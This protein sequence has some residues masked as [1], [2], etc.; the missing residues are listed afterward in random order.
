MPAHSRSEHKH[1][2]KHPKSNL[3]NSGSQRTYTAAVIGG[4]VAGMATAARLA[5]AGY[6]VTL[7]EAN[8]Y[9]GG[10]LSDEQWEGFRFDKGPSLF[11]MPELIDELFE[12]CGK[13]AADY[14]RYDRLDLVTRYF[15]GDGT[16]VNAYAQ[17]E[18]LAKELAQKVGEAESKVISYLNRAKMMYQTTAPVFLQRSLHDWRNL[19]RFS[20]FLKVLRIPWLGTHTTMHKFNKGWFKHERTV[21][22]FDRFAT[23]NGSDPYR[24]P[25]TLNLISYI[26]HGLGAYYPQGGMIAIRNALAQLMTDMGVNVRLQTRIDKFFI[27]ENKIKGVSIGDD[28]QVFDKVVSAVDITQVRQKLYPRHLR[29]K[30]QRND[31]LSTSAIIFHW[32][33]KGNFPQLDLHN[34]FFSRHYHKEFD[35]LKKGK[36]TN[37][38]TVYVYVSSKINQADAPQGHENWFVMVNTPPNQGQDWDQYIAQTRSYA[39]QILSEALRTPVSDLV[40]HETITDP[41]SLEADTGSLGGAIYGPASNSKWSAFL[42]QA[43]QHAKIKGLYFVGGSVHPGGGIPLCLLSARITTELITGKR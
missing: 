8:N 34:I 21:Q 23:Y 25:A 41:R 38:P 36:L 9:L 15:Y 27:F 42:R 3:K 16:V 18:K 12:A 37:D 17:P 43:N 11:T 29:K 30:Y 22:L 24:A 32:A 6:K 35:H 28:K 33:V 20:T 2:R 10:K 19:L 26:E 7:F 5:A 40:L 1:H 14:L 39:Q 31:E 4:G 13:N